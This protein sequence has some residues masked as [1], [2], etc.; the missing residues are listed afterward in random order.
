MSG[1]RVAETILGERLVIRDVATRDVTQFRYVRD[2]TTRTAT[3]GW[4]SSTTTNPLASYSFFAGES[5]TAYTGSLI[6]IL[7]IKKLLLSAEKG[8]ACLFWFARFICGICQ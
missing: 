7:L 1:P 8:A 4:M 5:T 2:G 3:F 6:D